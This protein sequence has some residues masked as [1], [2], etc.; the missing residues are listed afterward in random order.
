MFT[1][2]MDSDGGRA[3]SIITLDQS[4]EH[5]DVEVLIYDDEV[6]I[7]QHDDEY[8]STHIV[9][10]STQQWLDILAAM[11]LTDG[12]YYIGQRTTR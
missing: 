10:L 6:Y 1:V 5:E 8:D 2:E 11:N 7:Q 9:I 3:A 12:A 4:G